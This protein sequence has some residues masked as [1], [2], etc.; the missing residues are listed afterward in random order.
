[1]QMLLL[2]SSIIQSHES[3]SRIIFTAVLV[4]SILGC[5]DTDVNEIRTYSKDSGYWFAG[6]EIHSDANYLYVM[7]DAVYVF[8]SLQ[9][10]LHRSPTPK[11]AIVISKEGEFKLDLSN[12]RIIDL[13]SVRNEL[14]VQ[15]LSEDWQT[16]LFHMRYMHTPSV[17]LFELSD[18]QLNPDK[19]VLASISTDDDLVLL[20]KEEVFYKLEWVSQRRNFEV[21]LFDIEP[22]R[23]YK[24][25]VTRPANYIASNKGVDVDS[26]TF[27]DDSLM[28]TDG[29]SIILFNYPR[30]VI[31]IIRDSEERI[32]RK[33]AL[34]NTAKLDSKLEFV[35]GLVGSSRKN[36]YVG[37]SSLADGQVIIAKYRYNDNGGLSNVELLPSLDM[38]YVQDS[39]ATVSCLSDDIAV[40][41]KGTLYTIKK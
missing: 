7:A 17:P 14:G 4:V 21:E 30:D 12:S 10:V 28:A 29:E 22:I 5:S 32:Y 40:Q 27:Y 19:D 18:V 37:F 3:W 16:I 23:R 34:L 15:V 33:A 6:C 39:Y 41:Y 20:V 31:S 11:Y 26:A 24:D 2:V 25:I 8:E 9:Q 38:G 1:M 36:L 35:Q 13:E